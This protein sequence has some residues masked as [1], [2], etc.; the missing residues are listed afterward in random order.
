[1]KRLIVRE[2]FF[3]VYKEVILDKV[4][5]LGFLLWGLYIWVWEGLIFV[6]Y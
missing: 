4:V 6:L 3:L 2:R 1:M 5:F